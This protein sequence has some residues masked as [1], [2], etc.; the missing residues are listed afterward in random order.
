MKQGRN[1]LTLLGLHGEG[2]EN[3]RETESG[4]REKV[5]RKRWRGRDLPLQKNGRQEKEMGNEQSLS[6][7]GTFAP[8]YSQ[9]TSCHMQRG[10]CARFPRGSRN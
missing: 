9:G 1:T 8:E 4:E 6:L 2:R 7:K 10:D 3:E 5:G